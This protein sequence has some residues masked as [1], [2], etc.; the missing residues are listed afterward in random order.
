M[1]SE[2][3]F[4]QP[5]TRVSNYYFFMFLSVGAGL[6]Y[7]ALW[8]QSVGIEDHQIGIIKAAPSFAMLATT[9]VIG[10]WADKAADWRSAIL[11]CNWGVAILITCLL[12]VKGFLAILIV[13]TLSGLI[14]MAKFPILDAAAV[15]FARQNSIDYHKMRAFGSAGFIAGVL[16]AG[17]LLEAYGVSWFVVML[18]G[19]AWM[20]AL[21]SHSLPYFRSGKKAD[22]EAESSQ[23]SEGQAKPLGA[24]AKATTCAGSDTTV[25][26]NSRQVWFLLVLIASALIHGSHAYYYTFSAVLWSAAGYGTTKISILWALGV[27]IEILLMWKFSTVARRA[28]ARVLLIIAALVALLRWFVF[29]LDPDLPV[30]VL[31]QLLHGVT[32]AIMFLAT[33]N[34]IANWTPVENAARA[35]SISATL[36][37]LC[38]AL[39]T[40]GSGYLHQSLGEGGY[41]IMVLPCAVS[42]ICLLAA[43]AGRFGAPELKAAGQ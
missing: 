17:W 21:L 13:W 1:K 8:L 15:R 24:A 2:S 42:V 11:L 35:Q 43:T 36:N 28:S 10:H 41:L 39:G 22:S 29:S 40:L 5:S 12:L 37:T 27:V 32:F 14:M 23:A 6:P 38:M 9:I 30:L 26:D 25:V 19:F 7:F 3:P 4:V 33:V 31:A 20:R 18:A 34:F 16:L